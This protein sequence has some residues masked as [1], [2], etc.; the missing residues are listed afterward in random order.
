MQSTVS[1]FPPHPSP[2]LGL[3]LYTP[4]THSAT[5]F[6]QQSVSQ[7]GGRICTRETQTD[8]TDR[9]AIPPAK[10]PSTHSNGE[11]KLDTT[12]GPQIRALTD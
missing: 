6:P 1:L 12:L 7:S 9:Q 3:A 10:H 2:S 5:S 11:C 8:K 4:S